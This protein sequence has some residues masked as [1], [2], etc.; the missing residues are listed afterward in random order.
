MKQ[1]FVITFLLLFTF[2]YATIINVPVD[3]PTIQAGIDAAVDADTVLVQPGTYIEN[4][5]YNGK[6]ITVASLFLT[7]QDTSHISQT[8][9]DG[10]QITSVVKFESGEDSTAVLTGFTITNGNSGWGGG[11]YCY[12]SSPDINNVTITYN[13]AVQGGG[14]YCEESNLSLDNVTISYN[15]TPWGFGGSGGGI[16]CWQSTLTLENVTINGN[17]SWAGG[18]ILCVQGSNLSLTNVTISGNSN[19]LE[20]GSGGGIFCGNSSLNL[21]NVTIS[22]NFADGHGGGITCANSNPSLVNVTLLDNIAR[23]GGGICCVE[24]NPILTNVTI[25]DNLAEYYGGG[26]MCGYNSNPILVNCIIWNDS[27]EEIYFSPDDDPNSIT[28]SYS[29]IEGGETGIV[30]NNNGT[31]NWLEGNINEDPLFVGIGEHPYSL[32]ANSPCIDAGIPDTT[33]LNLPEYDLAGNPRI[34]GDRIDMGAYEW[35]GVYVTQN[36][37]PNTQYQLSNYPNPFNPTTTISFSI[38]EESNV[39]LSIYNIKGQKIKSLLSDQISSGEHSIVWDGEDFTGKK[40]GSGVYLYKLTLI[41]KTDAVKKCLLL[42]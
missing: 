3:Q 32:F 28:I 10:N 18:G 20:L 19:P 6:N 9:I 15:D 23:W 2:I 39:D 35:Q 12:Q 38:Q 29:D 24:S 36:L 4:I 30:T 25:T 5:N 13:D 16:C 42:K 33:G 37:I 41:G 31:V 14:I 7:T 1:K 34:F 26:I 40:V 21:V 22:Y 27:P 17:T 11:I 8:I